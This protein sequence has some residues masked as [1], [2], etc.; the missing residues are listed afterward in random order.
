MISAVLTVA[1]EL[2]KYRMESAMTAAAWASLQCL[3]CP[4]A[5]KVL[6]AEG[7]IGRLGR[8]NLQVDTKSTTPVVCLSIVVCVGPHVGHV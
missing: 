4:S 2:L 7:F 5:R 6:Q 8:L 1:V 3:R